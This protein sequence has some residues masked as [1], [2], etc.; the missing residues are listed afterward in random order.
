MEH[1]QML[2]VSDDVVV[3]IL[4]FLLT[5]QT[6]DSSI[7]MVAT[8]MI[9]N[10]N[11]GAVHELGFC[12]ETLHIIQEDGTSSLAKEGIRAGNWT[13][14]GI[15]MTIIAL[16]LIVYVIGICHKHGFDGRPR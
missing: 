12:A 4:S 7:F 3:E 1:S 2:A 9:A 13:W 6:G 5:H 8:V 11:V 10:S 14:E 16:S 15:I